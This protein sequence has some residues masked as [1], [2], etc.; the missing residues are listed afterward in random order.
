MTA[1]QSLLYE[2]QDRVA[3]ITLNKPDRLNALDQQ[4]CA[5]IVE[6]V[7]ESDRSDDVRVLVITGAGGRA[8]SSGFDLGGGASGSKDIDRWRKRI[9]GQQVFNFSVW[10][11][12]KPVIAMIEGHCLAGALEFA[13]MCDIRYASDD[14][15]FGAVETR[16]AAGIGAMVM[17]WLLGPYAREL[18]YSGDTIDAAEAVRIGLVN[19]VFPK[20]SL[21][22]ETLRFAKR[23]AQV[24]LAALQNNKRA[25]NHAYE[26]MGFRAAMQYGVE[27]C[28]AL[29]AT[30]TPEG[31]EFLERIRR[32][33]IRAAIRWNKERFSAF[34]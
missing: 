21:R 30:A 22:E 4:M 25:I 11:C 24:A 15:K 7:R 31:E 3:I 34:E 28:A 17:P 5:E 10:E 16:F 23:T 9:A 12:T 26:T 2:V 8:F 32:E 1:W 20:T 6:A 18:I 29:N 14:S 19:R 33:G 27:L 13:Q